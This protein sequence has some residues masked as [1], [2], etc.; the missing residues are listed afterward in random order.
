[1]AI[2]VKTLSRLHLGFMDLNGNLGRRYGSIGVTLANPC[3]AI[4]VSKSHQLNI[5]NAKPELEKRIIKYVTAFSKHFQTASDV[6]IRIHESIPE[7]KGLGSGSQLAL[8]ISTALSNFHGIRT[9]VWELSKLL[10]R[11]Q[12]SSIGIQS[13]QHGGL[14]IDSG[15]EL[16]VNGT[17]VDTPPETLLRLDFP[18]EWN[19]VVVVPDEKQ[20]LSGEQEKMAIGKLRPTKGTSEKICRLVMMQLLPS[21]LSRDIEKF[22]S[23]LSSIDNLTGLFFKPV[24]GGIYSEKQSYELTDHLL[25]SGAYGI[26]QSSWGPAIYGL[27][28]ASESELVADKMKSYLQ[29]NNIKSQVLITSAS[30]KGAEIKRVEN[31]IVSKIK[32]SRGLSF[33]RSRDSLKRKAPAPG[34]GF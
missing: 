4:T 30:N 26:G 15:K 21:F 22:G 19:F 33:E 28:L 34:V 2:Y 13:F 23:A 16:D 29:K 6:S 14:I 5:Q 24:Q 17:P 12:R 32:K 20:G 18:E 27:S 9:S 3:T 31:P 25:D 10:G 8:A 11:G 1:M 7:H